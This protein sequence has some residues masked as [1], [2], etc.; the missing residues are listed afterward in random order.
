LAG[1][2]NGDSEWAQ[3][4]HDDVQLVETVC[5]GEDQLGKHERSVPD[6]ETVLDSQLVDE[7]ARYGETVGKQEHGTDA[8]KNTGVLLGHVE[9]ILAKNEEGEVVDEEHNR[10]GPLHD[11]NGP[12][13]PRLVEHLALIFQGVDVAAFARSLALTVR[14]SEALLFDR[15]IA[16]TF[17]Y[18]AFLAGC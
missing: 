12:E 14:T 17:V 2:Q 9:L 5:E 11:E 3:G 1:E 7:I 18:R 8:K 15:V 10:G 16:Q 6:D 4:A 13:L